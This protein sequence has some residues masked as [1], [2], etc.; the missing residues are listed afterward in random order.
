[1]PKHRVMSAEEIAARMEM[2]KSGINPDSAGETLALRNQVRELEA[3]VMRHR[4]KGSI[5][6]AELRNDLDSI[7]KRYGVE[8]IEELLKLLME[9][10]PDGNLLM[11]VMDRAEVWQNLLQYRMPKLR[12]VEHTGTVNQQVNIVVMKFGT[13]EVI[14]RRPLVLDVKTEG[15]A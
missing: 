13:Q 4:D 11:G 1:M 6:P 14:E 15:E 10:G 3:E 12:A 9:R 2:R 7:L 5:S 8:P